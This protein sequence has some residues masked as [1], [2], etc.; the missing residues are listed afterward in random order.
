MN[1]DTLDGPDTALARLLHERRRLDLETLRGCLEEVRLD[2]TDSSLAAVL[3]ERGLIPAREMIDLLQEVPPRIDPAASDV[4]DIPTSRITRAA[5]TPQPGQ[6]DTLPVRPGTPVQP[7]PPGQPGQPAR[8]SLGPGTRL[9][10][11]VLQE[12]LGAGGMG[13][14]F[15]AQS[16]EGQNFALKTLHMGGEKEDRER[17]LREIEAQGRFDTHK[18]VI[19]VRSWGEANGVPYLVADLAE[20]GS[21]HQRLRSGPLSVH[22]AVRVVRDVALGLAHLHA[23]GVTHRDLKPANI[24]FDEQGT[25]KLVDFGL[26]RFEGARSLTQSGTMIG[27]LGY[28]A[29]EQ[30]MGSRGGP[31][32]DVFALG[33]VLH[34]CLASSPPFGHGIGSVDRVLNEEPPPLSAGLEGERVPAWLEQLYQ[35]LLSRDPLLRPSAGET[36]RLLDAQRAV[37]PSRTVGF[38]A[39]VTALA[40]VA[41]LTLGGALTALAARRAARQPG[42]AGAPGV[43]PASPAPR[44]T[45]A[46]TPP[47]PAPSRAQ[48]PEPQRV[49]GL[50]PGQ[51]LVAWLRTETQLGTRGTGRR[52]QERAYWFSW[53]VVAREGERLELEGRVRRIRVRWVWTSPES[54][55]L[56]DT[57]VS[58]EGIEPLRRALEPTFRL[59]LD[60]R[61]GRALEASGVEAIQ[62]AVFEGLPDEMS[63]RVLYS[64]PELVSGAAL[65]ETLD[66]LAGLAPPA[67][68][69]GE[70]WRLNRAVLAR[71]GTQTAIPAVPCQAEGSPAQGVPGTLAV[72]WQGTL[73]CQT[74]LGRLEVELQGGATLAASDRPFTARLNETWS[75][76]V[77][78]GCEAE[79]Q[80]AAEG[81]EV[82]KREVR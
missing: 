27:T 71:A 36:A 20:G 79:L 40:L 22:E 19:R 61:S 15:L 80:V 58:D 53:R 16:D 57:D 78:G 24:L 23:H 30:A 72:S 74:V 50:E 6:A 82:G 11:W 25:A 75:G 21:L 48:E 5:S 7:G 41:G 49:W 37:L 59:V 32:A 63:K 12:K 18:N 26:A 54:R 10:S 62:E 31:P 68:A 38:S 35:R 13:A 64:L 70:R 33:C 81:L 1:A 29:P 45:V 4:F 47:D 28:M 73:S 17:L 42:P 43:D 3:I 44:P 51:E 8:P 56:L 2:R 69:V 65:C 52:E 60:A 9:G 14:V 67:Q 66:G 55:G 76:A 34:T 39:G 77:V 46:A